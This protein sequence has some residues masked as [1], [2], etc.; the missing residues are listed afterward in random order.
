MRTTILII[1]IHLTI[2][3]FGQAN[4]KPPTIPLNKNI[5]VNITSIDTVSFGRYILYSFQYKK[6]SAF[7]WASRED[8]VFKRGLTNVELCRIIQIKDSIDGEEIN[9]RGC[10]F[11]NGLTISL[12]DSIIKQ[13]DFSEYSKSPTLRL[14]TTEK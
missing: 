3:I 8:M 1:F 13:Y 12:G 7:F 6:N 11:F 10:A 9:L 5:L 14:C 4:Q 2:S